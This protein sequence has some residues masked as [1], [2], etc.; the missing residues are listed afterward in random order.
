MQGGQPEGDFG[1]WVFIRIYVSSINCHAS[2]Q[3]GDENGNRRA[4]DDAVDDR[5]DCIGRA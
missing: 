2:K 1:H 3:D 5:H 4:E